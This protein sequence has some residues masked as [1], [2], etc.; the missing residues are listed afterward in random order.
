MF[1]LGFLSHISP[2]TGSAADRLAAAG[3]AYPFSGENIA[4][5]PTAEWL[6]RG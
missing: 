2:T 5:A 6:T 1:A 3:L 4:L